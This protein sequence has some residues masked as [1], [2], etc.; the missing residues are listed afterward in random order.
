MGQ[1]D[2]RGDIERASLQGSGN[3]SCSPALLLTV[4]WSP[5]LA[6]PCSSSLCSVGL[7]RGSAGLPRACGLGPV[8]DPAWWPGSSCWSQQPWEVGAGLSAESK[9][10]VCHSWQD[11]STQRIKQ[12]HGCKAWLV[13]GAHQVSSLLPC[14]VQE[15]VTAALWAPGGCLHL[16]SQAH[17][18]GVQCVG[19]WRRPGF[20]SRGTSRDKE[21]REFTDTAIGSFS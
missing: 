3:L 19:S 10:P 20:W 18:Q 8:I 6:R 21:Q 1:F 9:C 15:G 17:L 16:G 7:G 13:V 12:G 11:S 14:R 2:E 4:G 5:S